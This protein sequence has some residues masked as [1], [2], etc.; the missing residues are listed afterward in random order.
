MVGTSQGTS[1]AGH[2]AAVAPVVKFHGKVSPTFLRVAWACSG[3]CPW[4]LVLPLLML[5]FR[6]GQ[7]T[8]LMLLC[9]VF[10][11]PGTSLAAHA[12]TAL[13]EVLS[14]TE[15]NSWC[16][17]V[18]RG[19]VPGHIHGRTSGGWRGCHCAP[20]FCGGLLSYWHCGLCYMDWLL[21]FMDRA[22]VVGE[23]ILRGIPGYAVW[24]D[25]CNGLRMVSVA[26][27][28]GLCIAHTLA[29]AVILLDDP[30]H[31]LGDAG[32]K[33]EANGLER[34][35]AQP[36]AFGSQ[37]RDVLL[38]DGAVLLL[39]VAGKKV[40]ANGFKP[41]ASLVRAV[42]LAGAESMTGIAE[43]CV[44]G[45]KSLGCAWRGHQLMVNAASGCAQ[46]GHQL[47]VSA[48]TSAAVAID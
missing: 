40:E 39:G 27:R 14:S 35:A 7:N 2:A 26:G 15:E 24:M 11:P 19:R 12:V 22:Y 37:A 10:A 48:A 46:G 31:A 6:G 28:R 36:A 42:L 47:T 20:I 43:R 3:A 13:P 38:L 17:S 45:I 4:L 25:V 21:C 34:P 44:R 8:A 18:Q 32:E 1:R 30:V 5:K 23:C 33:V 29:D 41:P 16:S 9:A